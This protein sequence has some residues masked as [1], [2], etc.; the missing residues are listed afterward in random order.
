LRRAPELTREIWAAAGALGLR[1][2]YPQTRHHIID[3]QTPFQELGIPAVLII[4]YDYPPWHTQSDT[5][6]KVS[7]ASLGGVGAVLLKLARDRDARG[8]GR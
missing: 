4:D 5:I 7:P 2:W 3:D 6:D 1:G 8:A